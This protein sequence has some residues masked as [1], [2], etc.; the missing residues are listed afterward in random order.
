V[1]EGDRL[2]KAVRLGV[3]R[4]S[5]NLGSVFKPVATIGLAR[6]GGIFVA[7]APVP[8]GGWNYGV[9]SRDRPQKG[10]IVL[11]AQRPKLHYHRSGIVSATLT[12]TQLEHRSLHLPPLHEVTGAQ[13]L[14]ITCVRPWQLEDALG[15]HKGDVFNVVRSWPQSVAFSLSM[16][17]TPERSRPIEH[18]PDIAPLGLVPGDPGAFVVSLEG[19]GLNALLVGR[20]GTE[21][22]QVPGM[23]PG[24]SVTAM[25]WN[26]GGPEFIADMFSLWSSSLPNPHVLYE[27]RVSSPQSDDSELVV[28][29]RPRRPLAGA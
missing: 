21:Y 15:D 5:G 17:V 14:S 22:T 27:R 25:R 9:I 12:G 28:K 10:E 3:L 11:T 20:T 26:G 6:D 19:H 16:V 24:I 2:K 8:S 23:H 18:V 7:P 1:G 4:D 13:V 29:D